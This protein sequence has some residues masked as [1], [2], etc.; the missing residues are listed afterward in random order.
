MKRGIALLLSLCLCLAAAGAQAASA[1]DVIRADAAVEPGMQMLLETVLGAAVSTGV[2]GLE[3]GMSAPPA[4]VDAAFALGLY[5]LSLPHDGADLLDDQATMDA[6]EAQELYGL[7]FANG[8]FDASA[9]GVS[10]VS[11]V[12]AVGD[13]MRIDLTAQRSAPIIGVYVYSVAVDEA[14]IGEDGEQDVVELA[15]DLYSY[16]GDFST[17]VFD[18]PEDDLVWLC[19]A[20]VTLG[21]APETA[22]GCQI[23]QFALSERYEDG[24]LS[25]WQTV[26][27]NVCE[28]SVN[29]PGIL[30]LA[31]DDA[32]HTTWQT[33]DGSASVRIDAEERDGQSADQ[34]LSAFL[35]ANPGRTVHQNPEFSIYYSE[36]EG[37]YQQWIIS[38]DLPLLYHLTLQFPVERQAE[39]TL[40]SEFIR[41]SFIAWGISNG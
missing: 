1:R 14:S 2:N 28:Y 10:G 22:Y 12:T 25:E 31:E 15:A 35:A 34:V 13:G 21:V 24:M 11:G 8:S 5:N 26:E 18:L 40:Y 33:A 23:R 16:Y 20:E 3:E 38:E 37:N 36:A 19:N 29:L 32:A 41:N 39:Y 27:N 17:D 4:L 7:L 6:R 9:A 30:G